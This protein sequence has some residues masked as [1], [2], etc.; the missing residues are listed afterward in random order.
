MLDVKRSMYSTV[1]VATR[2]WAGY[3][4][5]RCSMPGRGRR[6][7]LLQTS[8]SLSTGVSS[9]VCEAAKA[10]SYVEV[11]IYTFFISLCLA[12]ST[13]TS[14]FY[15]EIFEKLKSSYIA[16]IRSLLD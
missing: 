4:S 11:E 13:R 5:N 2:V 6:F 9:V 7:S 8:C 16:E 1:G 14:Y 10:P 12:E 3:L 15:E